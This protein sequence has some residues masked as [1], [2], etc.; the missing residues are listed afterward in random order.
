MPTVWTW[1]VYGI[2]FPIPDELDVGLHDHLALDGFNVQ[3]WR[4]MGKRWRALCRRLLCHVSQKAG[5]KLQW[6]K[7]LAA[8]QAR[9][10][11][12]E[13]DNHDKTLFTIARPSYEEY[14]YKIKKA[15][16]RRIVANDVKIMGVA[17]S[18]KRGTHA[19]VAQ[20]GACGESG[21]ARCGAGPRVCVCACVL[22]LTCKRPF[23]LRGAPDCAHVRARVK[24]PQVG[25]T[26]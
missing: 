14:K 11:T 21:A 26:P 24:Y 13:I 3:Y 18:M 8:Q 6:M 10:Q 17:W 1:T 2:Q 5:S 25:A 12:I 23:R 15:R 9:E 16:K 20:C 4:E 7:E 19:W 22:G